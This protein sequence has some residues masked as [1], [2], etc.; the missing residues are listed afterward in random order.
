MGDL[1]RLAVEIFIFVA[2]SRRDFGKFT[3]LSK[4]KQAFFWRDLVTGH[5][6]EHLDLFSV[7][8]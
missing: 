2:S 3:I 8:G 7:Q 1:C 4:G 6:P 5:N